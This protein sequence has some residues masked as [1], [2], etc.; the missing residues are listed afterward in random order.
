MIGEKEKLGSQAGNIQL[1][2]VN[3]KKI[4]LEGLDF[5][6]RSDDKF[7]GQRIALDKFEKY[8]TRL[9]ESQL[10]V[11][12][13]VVDVGANIGYYTLLMAKRCKR[14]YAIE[15]DKRSFLILKKNVGVNKLKNV[16]LLNMAAGDKKE[17]KYLVW[18][19]NNQGNSQISDKN[20]ERVLIDTLDNIL[21]KEQKISLIKV[22]T[23]G[24]EAKVVEG[25]KKIMKRELP[26]LFLE[27]TP[28]EYIDNKMINFLKNN[29]Q[30]IWS[31]NDFAEVPW[32]IYRGVK[33]LGKSG[34]ADLFLKKKMEINDYWVMLKNIRYKKFI[35]GIINLICRK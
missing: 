25:A 34:Y 5:W 2:K 28:G 11:S 20:G 8:E 12:G 35:K 24:W 26:T 29:Y 13:V 27:Y 19:E 7:I 17:K 18:D 9:L 33:V 30:N 4:K 3:L 22:D 14:V 15:P 31:I 32:P 6:Y 23:Q 1:N 10:D 16:V 21:R